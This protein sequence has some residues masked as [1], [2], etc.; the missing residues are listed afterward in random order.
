MSIAGISS[1]R[2]LNRVAVIMRLDERE[3]VGG[4]APSRCERWRLERFAQ[5]G[6][7]VQPSLSSPI[8]NDPRG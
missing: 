2:R 6:C 1:G 7:H 3:P 4:R 8:R 5:S